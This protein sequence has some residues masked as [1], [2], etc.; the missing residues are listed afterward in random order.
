MKDLSFSFR[1]CWTCQ[2]CTL[3]LRNGYQCEAVGPN[4]LPIPL[5]GNVEIHADRTNCKAY[6][7]G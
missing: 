3:D 5:G 1:C 6:K 4:M 2:H 7:R